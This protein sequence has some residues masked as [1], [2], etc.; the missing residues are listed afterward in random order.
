MEVDRLNIELTE[1]VMSHR[2]NEEGANARGMDSHPD[3]MGEETD[4][5]KHRRNPVEDDSED[6]GEWDMVADVL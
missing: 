1:V 5:R 2:D 3:A 6:W 4:D